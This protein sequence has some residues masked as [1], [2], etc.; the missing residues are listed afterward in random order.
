MNAAATERMMQRSWTWFSVFQKDLS[1]TF[2]P[3][4][5]LFS[6]SGRHVSQQTKNIPIVVQGLLYAGKGTRLRPPFYGCSGGL[7][8]VAQRLSPYTPE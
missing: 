2:I 6:M 4:E 5:G 1:D 8:C 7:A 3:R